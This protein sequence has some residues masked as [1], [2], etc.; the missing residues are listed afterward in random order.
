MFGTFGVLHVQPDGQN[1]SMSLAE[2]ARDAM[3]WNAVSQIKFYKQLLMRKM[4]TRFGLEYSFSY[5]K[6]VIATPLASA[7]VIVLIILLVLYILCQR[8]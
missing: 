6:P 5:T 3:P 1:E 2:W 4:F 8:S 7:S